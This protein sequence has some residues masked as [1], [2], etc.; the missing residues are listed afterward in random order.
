MR[1]AL[2]ETSSGALADL[3]NSRVPMDM[4]DAWTL[5]L[6]G[7][8]VLRWSGSAVPI[9]A[10]GQV[11]S[12]GP[13][14]S[15]SGAAWKVGVEVQ[16]LRVT[17]WDAAGGTV[18]GLPLLQWLRAGGLAGAWVQLD[19]LFRPAGAADWTGAL[20]WFR[21]SVSDIESLDRHSV[22]LSVASP[23]ELLN[24]QVPAEVVQA[25][26][27]NTLFDGRCGLARST[28]RRTGSV[29]LASDSRRLVCTLSDAQSVT[30][31]YQL[32]ILRMT[33]G[34]NAG[35]QRTVREHVQT[36]Q[37]GVVTVMR[38]WPAPLAVGD[39][40]E[41]LPGCNKTLAMC[42]DKYANRARFRGLPFVPT[43][44]TVT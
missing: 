6:S 1:T 23:L 30:Q 20:A 24:V 5:T 9:V 10:N 42:T 28:W 17:L 39:Q 31:W 16:R 22:S 8:T 33:S 41:A 44:D 15:R 36:A 25:Q 14:I 13:A 34:A 4:A 21:G 26:C 18:G 32:G 43:P 37:G 35:V 29:V 27:L 40:W 11:W 7:G 19:R 3:L 2:W 12:L 38:P